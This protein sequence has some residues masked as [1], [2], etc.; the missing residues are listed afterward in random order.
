MCLSFC[1]MGG[2]KIKDIVMESVISGCDMTYFTGKL[3][4]SSFTLLS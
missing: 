1:Y 3:P 2:H 4:Y